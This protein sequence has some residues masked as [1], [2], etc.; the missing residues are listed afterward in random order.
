MKYQRVGQDS[1]SHSPRLLPILLPELFTDLLHGSR[2][3]YGH[4]RQ[5]CGS[6]AYTFN[7]PVGSLFN[8]SRRYGG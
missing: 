2:M 5:K 7:K 4:I 1:R 6:L 3:S 8:N